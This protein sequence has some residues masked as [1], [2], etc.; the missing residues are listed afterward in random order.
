MPPSTTTKS[1]GRTCVYMW[2]V[3]REMRARAAKLQQTYTQLSDESSIQLI[4]ADLGNA[5]IEVTTARD[6]TREEMSLSSLA[7]CTATAS[8]HIPS[9]TVP[10]A[11]MRRGG[12]TLAR[13]VLGGAR[14]TRGAA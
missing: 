12:R 14:R 6:A 9:T 10:P 2:C 1:D 11:R 13:V 7:A 4:E 3:A 5:Y 8:N